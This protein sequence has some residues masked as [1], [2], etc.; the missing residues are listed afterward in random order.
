PEGDA[1]ACAYAAFDQPCSEGG[2]AR[3]ECAVR[4]GL[5]AESDCRRGWRDARVREQRLGQIQR[6][7]VLQL[8]KRADVFWPA[9]ARRQT[10]GPCRRGAPRAATTP[11]CCR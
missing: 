7:R 5:A 8:R 6:L 2:G 10:V 11:M 3:A 4:Q 1:V 9:L